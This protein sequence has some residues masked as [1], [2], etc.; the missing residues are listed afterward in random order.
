MKKIIL[1]IAF[2]LTAFGTISYAA[3]PY[4]AFYPSTKGPQYKLFQHNVFNFEVDLPA[5]W[6]FGV[7]GKPPG[8]V[9]MMYPG[10]LNTGKFSPGYETISIGILP[11]P[12][13]SL[14]DAHE[15]T[16]LG[17]KQVHEG[18]QFPNDKSKG[19]I[20]GNES[21][22]FS[23]IWS[24]KTGNKI[25]ENVTLVKYKDRVYSVNVRTIEP[26]SEKSI[27]T[28]NGIISTFKPIAPVKLQ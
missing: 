13:I 15:A 10:K 17:M 16:T 23:Y 8:Q 3:S 24:S 4:Y 9:I 1:L 2:A 14:E 6:T 11:T 5:D 18:I 28:H 21:L 12:N 22:N 25:K 20:N 27:E 7:A 19:S 26:I